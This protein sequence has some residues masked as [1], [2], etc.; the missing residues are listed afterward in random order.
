M[1]IERL[2]SLLQLLTANERVSAKVL[3]E[4]LE[5]SKR[6]IYRDIDTL[7]IV[8]IPIISY[9]SINGGY[10]VVE[11]YKINQQI[12][13]T[14]DVANILTG[15]FALKS[16]AEPAEIS[17]LL[18]KIAPAGDEQHENELLIDLSS[19][20]NSL[21]QKRKLNELRQAIVLK[22][23]ILLRYHSGKSYTERKIEPYKLIFKATDWYLYAFCLKR[24]AFRLFKFARIQSYEIKNETFEP[25]K[26]EMYRLTSDGEPAVE[27]TAMQASSDEVTLSYQLKDKAFLLERLDASFFEVHDSVTQTGTI[28]FP[29]I[30]LEKTVAFI[31]RLQDKV[32]VIEPSEVVRAVQEKIE[33]MYLFYKS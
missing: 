29:L 15:L 31:L 24:Q 2:L 23:V 9:S 3:A 6:T 8:G 28:R 1:K 14:S 25:R 30:E 22:Q 5:V 27:D 13:S 12:F 11:G 32:K 21:N 18:A 17:P 7:N 20:S 26:L 33:K 10:G 4:R 16:I 19:W